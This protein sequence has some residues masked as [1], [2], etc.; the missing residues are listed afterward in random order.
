MSKL[1]SL[2]RAAGNVGVTLGVAAAGAA[3]GFATERYVVG[4]SLRGEDPYAEEPLGTLRGA[5]YTLETDDGVH[6]HVEVDEPDGRPDLTV[7]FSHGYALNLDAW[8]FQRRDLRGHARLVFWDQRSHGRSSRAPAGTVSFARLAAD[9]SHV[10]DETVPKR[11]PL[12]LVGHSMGG[13]TMLALAQT[14]PELFTER[15]A[16]IGLVA[17]SHQ[18][19]SA[20]LGMPGPAGQLAHRIAPGLVAALARQ[21]DLIERGRR[22]GSDLGYVL[23]RRYSFVGKASP[24]LVAFTAQMNAATPID[25]VAEFLPLFSANDQRSAAA[26]LPAVPM[27]IVGAVD[28][29]LTPV[30]HSRELA[31]MRPEAD[32]VELPDAGHM[33]LLERHEVVTDHLEKLLQRARTARAPWWRRRKAR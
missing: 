33:V 18:N 5:P 6:L 13:M 1:L 19:I 4:R 28:D 9:L 8:H 31:D 12:V 2:G 30:E 23:T 27:L 20:T 16:G 3:V 10:I 25:V 32:Y 15:V 22:A 24:S 29:R 11:G 26:A 7:V 21:P 14:R 17:T